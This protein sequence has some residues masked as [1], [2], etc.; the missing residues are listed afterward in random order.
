MSDN[1]TANISDHVSKLESIPDLVV[2]TSF[3]ALVSSRSGYRDHRF[4]ICFS[5]SELESK[6]ILKSKNQNSTTT[7]ISL[8]REARKWKRS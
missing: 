4:W 7:T 2:L 8:D 1:L 6:W 5:A 3:D